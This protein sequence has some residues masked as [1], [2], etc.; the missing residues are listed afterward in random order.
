MGQKGLKVQVVCTNP[1]GHSLPPAVDRNGLATE[2]FEQYPLE[3]RGSHR[4][5]QVSQF[6]LVLTPPRPYLVLILVSESPGQFF[7]SPYYV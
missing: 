7:G 4:M 5:R 2:G 1:R 6:S 3:S